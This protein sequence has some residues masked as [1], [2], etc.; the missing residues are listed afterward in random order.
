GGDGI[1]LT[2]RTVINNYGGIYGGGGGGGSIGLAYPINIDLGCIPFIGCFNYDFQ[3][4][5]GIGGGGG[6]ASGL[7][8]AVPSGSIAIC[9]FSAGQ[10]ATSGHT[11]VPGNGNGLAVPISLTYSGVGVQITPTGGG[12]N[13]GAFGQPGTSGS[14]SVC[15][16]LVVPIVG[17]INLACPNVAN[18]GSPGQP[19]LAIKRNGNQLTGVADGTYNNNQ[20]KG[21]VTP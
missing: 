5:V 9:S 14:L 4:G 17:N 13:G 21:Q 1:H 8:G 12:G 18:P 19:G 3:I 20:V 2:T 10:D 16:A 11:S 15:I 7:G 6:S